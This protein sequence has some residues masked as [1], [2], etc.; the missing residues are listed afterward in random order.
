MLKVGDKIKT[1]G[2]IIRRD[3]RFGAMA[4]KPVI[5]CDDWD[6]ADLRWEAPAFGFE[7]GIACNVTVT[8]RAVIYQDGCLWL[9]G[10]LEWVKDGDE[11][12]GFEPVFIRVDQDRELEL[13]NSWPGLDRRRIGE[14]GA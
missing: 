8:G 1:Y 7:R 3:K 9:R 6:K 5:L 11:P 12:S 13:T 10:R 2:A 14:V 4:C